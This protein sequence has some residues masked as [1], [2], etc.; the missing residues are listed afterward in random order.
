MLERVSGL[1][2][3]FPRFFPQAGEQFLYWQLDAA[4]YHERIGTVIKEELY[5]DALAANVRAYLGRDDARF[6][7]YVQQVIDDAAETVG[8]EYFNEQAEVDR[9]RD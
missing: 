9:S 3:D 2:G 7:W 5:D 8:C 1:D 4:C 6:S